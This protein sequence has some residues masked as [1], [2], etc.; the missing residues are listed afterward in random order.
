M[1]NDLGDGSE[2][3]STGSIVQEDDAAELDEP[4]FTQST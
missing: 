2:L 3:A 1:I 4:G